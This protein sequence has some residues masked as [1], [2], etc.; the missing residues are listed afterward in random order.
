MSDLR[1]EASTIASE[2]PNSNVAPF[3]LALPGSQ[4]VNS[5][6]LMS[7]R[8]YAHSAIGVSKFDFVTSSPSCYSIEMRNHAGQ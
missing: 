6:L 1:G 8:R 5:R 4:P 3:D 7:T 2:K